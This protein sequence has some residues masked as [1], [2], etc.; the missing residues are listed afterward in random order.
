MKTS[1][2]EKNR[3]IIFLFRLLTLKHKVKYPLQ[4]AP[5][6]VDYDLLA[7]LEH[8]ICDAFRRTVVNEF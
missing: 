6:N 3:D 7:A 5:Y 8:K 4:G 1:K 2:E